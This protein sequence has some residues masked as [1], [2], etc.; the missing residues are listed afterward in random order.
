MNQDVLQRVLKV[1]FGHYGID[2]AAA[3]AT[4]EDLDSLLV[5]QL[6]ELSEGQESSFAYLLGCYD[7]AQLESRNLS[8]RQP[9]VQQSQEALAAVQELCVS[10]AGL[11]L[12]DL[13]PQVS[14]LYAYSPCPSCNR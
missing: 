1:S 13:F 5:A 8:P 10:Y 11:L 4:R 14:P 6:M 12:R 7:R 2:V 9:D 3:G